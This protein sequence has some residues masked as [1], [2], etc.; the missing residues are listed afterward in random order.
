[1]H[2]A[3]LELMLLLGEMEKRKILQTKIISSQRK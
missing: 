3:A 1:V 2:V